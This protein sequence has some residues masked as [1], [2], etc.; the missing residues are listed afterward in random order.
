MFCYF[1]CLSAST[2]RQLKSL[3]SFKHGYMEREYNNVRKLVSVSVLTLSS[4]EK[5]LHLNS[6]IRSSPSKALT[7]MQWKLTCLIILRGR[8]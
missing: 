1:M 7:H 3:I 5:L 2:I 8:P 4:Y 6:F